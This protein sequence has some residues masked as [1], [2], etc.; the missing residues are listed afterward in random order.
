MR[1]KYP[2]KCLVCQAIV[3]SNQGYFQRDTVN[4]KWFVRCRKCVGKGNKPVTINPN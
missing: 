4:H 3:E 2:G 1:N